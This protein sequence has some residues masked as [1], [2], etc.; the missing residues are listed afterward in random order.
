MVVNTYDDERFKY[1]F[2][3]SRDTF[4]FILNKI[5]HRLQK[6]TITEVPISPEMRLAICLYKLGRGDY[7]YTIGEMTGIA[8]SNVC[9]IVIEVSE[10]I[11]E[12]LWE[13][14]VNKYFPKTIEQYETC[15]MDMDEEWQFPFASAAIDG[16]HSC[17]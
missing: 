2:R 6:Q 12:V 14:Y 10:L 5:Q 9:R 1:T 11:A 17:L 7:H 13:D 3:V 4:E 15:L 16:S 8:Q